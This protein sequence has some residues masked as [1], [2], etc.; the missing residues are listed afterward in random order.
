M[1]IGLPRKFD[2]TFFGYLQELCGVRHAEGVEVELA[3]EFAPKRH[4][5]VHKMVL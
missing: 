1:L 3:L 4:L 2:S 5:D